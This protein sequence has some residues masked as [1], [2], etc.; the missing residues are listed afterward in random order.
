VPNKL[1]IRDGASGFQ[2]Y[3]GF[4][5]LVV[6]N[7]AGGDFNLNGGIDRFG[8]TYANSI[9]R[10]NGRQFTGS[11]VFKNWDVQYDQANA[12]NWTCMVRTENRLYKNTAGTWAIDNTEAINECAH[13]YTTLDNVDGTHPTFGTN[14]ALHYKYVFTDPV[15]LLAITGEYYNIGAWAN[16]TFP[17]PLTT[18]NA[19]TE[20][21]GGLYGGDN[22]SLPEPATIDTRNLHLTH[23]GGLAFNEIDGDDAGLISHLAFFQKFKLQLRIFPAGGLETPVRGNFKFKCICGDTSDNVVSLDYTIPIRNTWTFQM[24]ELDAFETY[25]GR[26]PRDTTIA[27][28]LP[29][30]ELEILNVFEWKNL[31]WIVIQLQEVYDDNG[32]FHPLESDLYKFAQITPIRIYSGGETDLF[33]DSFHFV[34]PLLT[35]SATAPSPKTITRDE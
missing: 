7:P 22:K 33:L 20:F 18:D 8:K 2:F 35:S 12:E 17:L 32:R 14:S 11:D 30:K 24:L 27:W 3:R 16:V 15:D 28:L 23:S 31:K 25:R 26:R 13:F 1:K 10:H 6:G 34:K 19:I 5:I 29:P 9:V 4:R 21:V